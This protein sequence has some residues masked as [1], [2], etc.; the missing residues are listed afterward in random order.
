M[1]FVYFSLVSFK[2]SHFYTLSIPFF[3]VG[4]D[5]LANKGTKKIPHT[6][7]YAGFSLPGC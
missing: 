7:V 3:S 2:K 5:R 6:Q 4:I 1:P